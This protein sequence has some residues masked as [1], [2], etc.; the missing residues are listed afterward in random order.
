LNQYKKPISEASSQILESGFQVYLDGLDPNLPDLKKEY[1][2]MSL[3]EQK[4][5]CD[6]LETLKLRKL[7]ELRACASEYIS[8]RCTNK[9]CQEGKTTYKGCKDRSFCPRCAYSYARSRAKV[10]YEYLKQI[11]DAMPFDLKMNQ[12]TLTVPQHMERMPKPVLTFMVKQFLKEL[13][14]DNYA[15]ELQTAR[16]RDPLGTRR[17]HAHVLT[18][19][20]KHDGKKFLMTQYWF[21][22]SRL[23]SMWKQII[24][25]TAGEDVEGDVDLHSEFASIIHRKNSVI[26]I[27]QY[28]YRYPVTDLFNAWRK[29]NGYFNTRQINGTDYFKSKDRLTWCGLMSPHGRVKLQKIL[30]VKL[31]TLAFLKWKLGKEEN[32]CTHCGSFYVVVDRGKYEGD[33]EPF[34]SEC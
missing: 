33:N 8:K 13:G 9:K 15:Y 3:E 17:V 6:F 7:D 24:Q 31:A 26:H 28:L 19:N 27:L 14:I 10:Q 12:I 30:G 2:Y 25:K 5:W 4:S 20:F 16:S 29:D 21:D 34:G 22:L 1:R 32:K 23:R 11:A 18:F